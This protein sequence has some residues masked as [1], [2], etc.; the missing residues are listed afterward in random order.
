[1]YNVSILTNI[2]QVDRGKLASTRFVGDKNEQFAESTTNQ[3]PYK[4]KL[5]AG[6]VRIP[7][8]FVIKAGRCTHPKYSRCKPFM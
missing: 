5:Q 3:Y 2:S 8:I 4:A 7:D 6:L 1:L